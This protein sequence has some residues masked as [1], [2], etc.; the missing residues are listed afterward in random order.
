[1]GLNPLAE[2]DAFFTRFGEPLIED[3]HSMCGEEGADEFGSMT[4]GKK[5]PDGV[6]GAESKGFAVNAD[7]P[8]RG[9]FEIR[10]DA[11]QI[12]GVFHGE[13]ERAVAA[14]NAEVEEEGEE[15]F[16]GEVVLVERQN[17]LDAGGVIGA[18]GE[19]GAE[20]EIIRGTKQGGKPGQ[21]DLQIGR[22]H[23]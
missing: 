5:E 12:T 13:N 18:R 23:V 3:F 6:A 9:E 14:F 8:R 1:M 17:L 11:F 4:P 7:L 16:A 22:A 2:E 21:D 15:P 19:I 20:K 10:D